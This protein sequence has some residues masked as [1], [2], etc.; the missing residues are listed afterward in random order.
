V[1][2]VRVYDEFGGNLLYNKF[3]C[4][5]SFRKRGITDVGQ[6][7]QAQTVLEHIYIENGKMA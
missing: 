1:K 3:I 7:G 5:T 4:G 2:H 6:C